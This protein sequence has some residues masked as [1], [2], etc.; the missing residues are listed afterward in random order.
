[1]QSIFGCEILVAV[2]FFYHVLQS[3]ERGN[4]VSATKDGTHGSRQPDLRGFRMP[5]ESPS[6]GI[7]E[8]CRELGELLGLSAPVPPAVLRAAVHDSTYAQNL[9][10][11]RG[12]KRF[13]D[14]LIAHPPVIAGEDDGPNLL[15]L[16]TNAA[17]SLGLWAR[18]GFST[19]SDDRY[20]AR[21]DACAACPHLRQPP[22]QR[23][24]LYAV[25]GAK[26][27]ERSMCGKCGCLVAAKARRPRDTCP[28]PHPER[29]GINRWGEPIV[30]T[31]SN[32]TEPRVASAAP[33][34]AEVDT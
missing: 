29:P 3:S 26:P 24:L 19:V 18:T 27:N 15:T 5:N 14:R 8:Q 1:V 31:S 12:E 7:E 25:A 11:S 21:L 23:R 28:D 4:K 33:A 30:M 16:A 22:E 13:L 17:I 32:G 34:S 6:T 20:A 2:V 10:I 9:L